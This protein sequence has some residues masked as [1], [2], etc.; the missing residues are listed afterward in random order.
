MQ[1]TH[2]AASDRCQHFNLI[3]RSGLEALERARAILRKQSGL[4]L[5]QFPGLH[6]R[7]GCGAQFGRIVDVFSQAT[8]DIGA[9]EALLFVGDHIQNVSWV[10]SDL[11][12]DRMRIWINR[13]DELLVGVRLK[14]TRHQIGAVIGCGYSNAGCLPKTINPKRM[15][16]AQMLYLAPKPAAFIQLL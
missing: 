12:P 5:H 16:M 8:Q 6:H 9:G 7:I 15:T 11:R 10:F 13:Y 2:R 4:D 14:E 1:G 3:C